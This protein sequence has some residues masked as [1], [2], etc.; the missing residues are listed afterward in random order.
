MLALVASILLLSKYWLVPALDYL[1][2]L[3][4]PLGAGIFVLIAALITAATAIFGATFAFRIQKERER[5]IKI[6][7][8]AKSAYLEFVSS[9]VDLDMLNYELKI[10]EEKLKAEKARYHLAMS[11]LMMLGSSEAIDAALDYLVVVQKRLKENEQVRK[12][13]PGKYPTKVRLEDDRISVRKVKIAQHSF[14]EAAR[15]H[16]A[17]GGTMEVSPTV[18]DRLATIRIN[19]LR[20]D[21]AS[22][23]KG[24]EANQ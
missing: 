17:G 16:I 11:K 14:V 8:D 1:N 20:E 9:L 7:E 4:A 19:E 15:R 12:S 21:N 6:V 2:T 3:Q 13:A 10:N 18:F 24:A 23:G 5:Q 22:D